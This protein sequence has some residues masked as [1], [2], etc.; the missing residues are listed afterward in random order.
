LRRHTDLGQQL[1][2]QIEP[3]DRRILGDV[4]Q[5]IGGAPKIRT[6]RQPTAPAT[7]AQ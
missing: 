4:A 3:P 5:E 7:R 2:R 6:E 1:A